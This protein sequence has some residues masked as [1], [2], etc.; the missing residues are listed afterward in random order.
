MLLTVVTVVFNDLEGL[1]RTRK[2]VEEILHREVEYW[3]IDGST[4]ESIKEYLTETYHPQIKWI[5]ERDKGLYDAMNKGIDRATGDY[6]LFMNAGDCIHSKFKLETI[7]QYEAP[8]TPVVLGYSVE[9]FESDMYL[10]PGLGQEANVFTSAAH[11][12]TFYPKNFYQNAKY[13]L[14]KPVGADGEFTH[15]AITQ[16]GAVFIPMMVCKFELGGLSSNY[17][18]L[19]SLKYRLKEVKSL[20]SIIK[21][22]FKV[23]IWFLLPRSLFYRFLASYKYTRISSEMEVDLPKQILTYENNTY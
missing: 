17:G 14:D 12:A 1:I 15:R 6:L 4:N 8:N 13:R 9:K 10:R 21:L 20:K 19:K 23:V 3:I 2:S 16:C 7:S 22:T 5:S 18:S 11:Q